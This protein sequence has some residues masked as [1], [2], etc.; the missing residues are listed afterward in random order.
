[1]IQSVILLVDPKPEVLSAIKDDLQRQYNDK[2]QV[3]Q[4]DSDSAALEKLK[5]L[6]KNKKKKSVTL[7]VVEQQNSQIAGMDFLK[8]A[9]EIFPKAK[10]FLLRIHDNNDLPNQL[11]LLNAVVVWLNIGVLTSPAL[12]L[13][14]ISSSWNNNIA[15]SVS[16]IGWE[17]QNIIQARFLLKKVC[18]K[19]EW[20][21]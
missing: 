9:I 21:F 17:G 19:N 1:M 11:P 5:K 16:R 2:L 14:A 4:A 13:N 3:I 18:C 7:F 10:Q 6:K 8:M 12:R 20:G 15:L